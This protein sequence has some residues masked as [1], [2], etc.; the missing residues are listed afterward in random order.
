MPALQVLQQVARVN[1]ST[2]AYRALRDSKQVHYELR[3]GGRLH[4][5]KE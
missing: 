5:R 1:G 3:K 4:L 2:P